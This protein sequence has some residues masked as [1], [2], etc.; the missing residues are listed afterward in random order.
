MH[1]INLLVGHSIRVAVKLILSPPG[2]FGFLEHFLGSV[3]EQFLV[4]LRMGVFP[5]GIG[6]PSCS[7]PFL[8]GVASSLPSPAY[9]GLLWHFLEWAFS[10]RVLP[11]GYFIRAR[12]LIYCANV[13]RLPF[14][15]LDNYNYLQ[16]CHEMILNMMALNQCHWCL[17][18]RRG[19]IQFLGLLTMIR[20]LGK[21]SNVTWPQIDLPRMYSFINSQ[22][23]KHW[24]YL[25]NCQ[26]FKQFKKSQ[27]FKHRITCVNMI[28]VQGHLALSSP[29]QLQP[30]HTQ[31]VPS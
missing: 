10:C 4:H 11:V 15:V 28:R 25:K 24:I 19:C 1:G 26:N 2:H 22:N 27:N 9:F 13:C 16:E 3:L 23:L 12:F 6:L 31:W 29:L 20:I 17:W 7:T 21:P 5:Q 14:I 8:C 18:W 30:I